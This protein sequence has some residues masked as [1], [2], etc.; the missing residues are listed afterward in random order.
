MRDDDAPVTLAAPVIRSPARRALDL[1]LVLAAAPL[2]VPLLAAVAGATVAV[3]GRPAFYSQTRMG[4]GGRPFR[5]HKIRTMT[6][7]VAPP[8]GVAFAGWTYAGDPR[9]TPL[10]RRLRRYRL[11]EL[12]Q[13]WNVLRGD[14]SLVGPRPEPWEVAVALGRQIPG[15]H[16][17][18]R[19]R[20]GLTGLCQVSRVYHDFGTVQ[21]SARKLRLDL[22]Y[23]RR[24]SP[25]FD[26]R[27]L[28]RTV[29]VLLR[30]GGVA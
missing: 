15:Y 18:H 21:K 14:M 22:R 7:G 9:V 2:W 4:W 5:I 8:P 1:A 6:D 19:V 25:G 13:L 29:R 3:S 16:E 23:V 11:D 27:I 30:G 26:L 10:G 12:P 24:A 17:R 28:L 20:P